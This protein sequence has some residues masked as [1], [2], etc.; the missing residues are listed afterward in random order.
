MGSQSAIS[1]ITETTYK[2]YK[3]PEQRAYENQLYAG[4]LDLNKWRAGMGKG[5]R[6]GDQ[7]ATYQWLGLPSNATPEQYAIARAKARGEYAYPAP[8]TTAGAGPIPAGSAPTPTVKT[9]AQGGIMQVRGFAGPTGSH[10]KPKPKPKPQ[11]PAADVNTSG[12]TAAQQ[13]QWDKLE[14]A[15]NAGTM[16]PQQINNWNNLNTAKTTYGKNNPTST[17]TITE[18]GGPT[19]SG[20]D[21]DRLTPGMY[22]DSKS[23]QIQFND[24]VY[25]QLQDRLTGG[26]GFTEANKYMSDAA[27]GLGG[28]ANYQYERV[29]APTATS[30]DATAGQGAAQQA[31]A[32]LTNR[33]DIRDVTAQQALVDKYNAQ[34]MNAPKDIQAQGYEA[35]LMQGPSSW[36]DAGT[37]QKYMDPYMQGVIDISK[38]EAG[39]EFQ[40]QQNEMGAK[41]ARAGA[42]GGARQSLEK[43]EATRNYNQQLQDMQTKGLSQ[44]Y[45]S[46]MSQYGQESQLTQAARQAN[47]QALNQQQQQFVQNALQ[48][49][50][51]N[52][53]GQLT[54]EQQ[55]QVAANAAA[56]FNSNS[57]NQ[58]NTLYV[59]QMLAA[60][61][62][63]QGV[64]AQTAWNNAQLATQTANQNAS[65]GTQASLTNADLATRAALQN[66]QMSTQT[67]WQNA[68]NLL[69]ARQ[70]NQRAGLDANQQGITAYNNMGNMGLG[71]GNIN[72]TW[73]QQLGDWAKGKYGMGTD[74][75][76][77]RADNA[78]NT[79]S[80]GLPTPG[81]APAG[82]GG[83]QTTQQ[84]Y[85]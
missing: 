70:G 5:I 48:A 37:S 56:Q 72:Q 59:T 50:M 4:N 17:D 64:D 21:T 84:T 77:I 47:Q 13:K 45:Q 52:Y 55:N 8:K 53:G 40:K 25:Q 29:D 82:G 81:G 54:A 33:G 49:A 18:G 63:N 14:K 69:A 36:T 80:G 32:S 6:E 66:A 61:Q 30:S 34:M 12:F 62:M 27:K 57:Q 67:S 71:I 31:E 75:A 83:K 78:R 22:Y 20:V 2:Q 41:A 23:N 60:Q 16:T 26:A 43:A 11:A 44:A 76:N 15:R 35:A 19:F 74:F 7:K 46:G 3:S 65:L 42:F 1:P 58:S 73:N 51:T 68:N 85:P 79:L 38:R 28:L 10:V 24:P 39:R 9:A